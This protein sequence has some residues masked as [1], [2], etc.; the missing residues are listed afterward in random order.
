M[1]YSKFPSLKKKLN[2]SDPLSVFIQS[3]NL[4]TKI[5][6]RKKIDYYSTIQLAMQK[7]RGI[8]QIFNTKDNLCLARGIARGMAKFFIKERKLV[9]KNESV[10][11]SFSF[12]NPLTVR[13]IKEGRKKQDILAHALHEICNISK[14]SVH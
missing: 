14:K 2:L 8:I 1:K 9:L 10:S 7:K 5:G 11:Y 13:Y 6:S 3:V 12:N 4:K